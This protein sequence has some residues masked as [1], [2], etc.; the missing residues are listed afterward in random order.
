VHRVGG[1]THEC[2][3]SPSTTYTRSLGLAEQDGTGINFAVWGATVSFKYLV[4]IL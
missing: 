2:F 3:V 4:V 1:G